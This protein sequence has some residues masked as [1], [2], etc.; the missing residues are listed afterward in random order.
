MTM[1]SHTR[2]VNRGKRFLLAW[3]I[4]AD[5][6]ISDVDFPV[7]DMGK[8]D[9]YAARI[10]K[11]SV[12]SE[13]IVNTPIFAEAE[14]DIAYCF[15]NGTQTDGYFQ[16]N[17]TTGVITLNTTINS[18]QA[19]A[20]YNLSIMAYEVAEPGRF[21]TATVYVSNTWSVELIEWQ[22]HPDG[23]PF[24]S[25]WTEGLSIYADSDV[26]PDPNN[27]ND[28]FLLVNLLVKIHGV[29]PA[30]GGQVDLV[31]L[32][33]PNESVPRAPGHENDPDNHDGLLKDMPP[34]LM[35]TPGELMKTVTVKVGQ[36]AGDNY[37]VTAT[38]GTIP[39][40]KITVDQLTVWRRLWVEC[41]FV[42]YWDV[43]YDGTNMF[44]WGVDP[45]AAP[46]PEAYLGHSKEQLE[47]ACVKIEMYDNPN[48]S[49]KIPSHNPM[50]C[51]EEFAR[52]ILPF[53]EELYPNL[54]DPTGRDLPK[55][56]TSAFWTVRIL[57]T[58]NY[59]EIKRDKDNKPILDP[60]GNNI[61]VLS[62]ANGEFCGGANT[63][64]LN[65]HNLSE[66]VSEWN[67]N[68]SDPV[69][70][71]TLNSIISRTLLHE[72]CHCLIDDRENSVFFVGGALYN[73]LEVEYIDTSVLGV[74][75]TFW[76]GAPKLP[77]GSLNP[78]CISDVFRRMAYSR[79]TKLDIYEIQEKS[80]A[81]N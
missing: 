56:S 64:V 44:V 54:S 55:Q 67:N 71:V 27:P 22:A 73:I 16:I 3:W 19:S 31:C 46:S 37:K 75:D 41:D 28:D 23:N 68:Q 26:P 61:F 65:Y 2:R 33:M 5:E 49:P 50:L 79:L 1:L 60:S 39:N 52:D 12:G 70:K 45:I 43:P 77:D 8:P 48:P 15:S 66:S 76:I 34:P 11:L 14:R 18:T 32:D 9:D 59:Y 69:K 53:D 4:N 24:I 29:V 38:G 58:P 72:L 13:L 80:L 51:Y 10:D 17:A 7:Y 81:R 25:M 36:K 30:N 74:R 47:R 63:I 40:T 21:D 78:N 62:T 42:K 35:F 20:A 6:F 57:M